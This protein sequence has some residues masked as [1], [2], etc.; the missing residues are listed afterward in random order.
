MAFWLSSEHIE[1][2]YLFNHMFES[3]LN[4]YFF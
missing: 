3:S 1:L 4:L 2:I